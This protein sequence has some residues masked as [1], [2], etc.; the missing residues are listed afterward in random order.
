MLLVVAT[1]LALCVP[2]LAADNAVVVDSDIATYA[3]SSSL[4]SLVLLKPWYHSGA[5]ASVA[6]DGD[7][8]SDSGSGG[9]GIGRAYDCYLYSS[10]P[11]SYSKCDIPRDYAFYFTVDGVEH[12]FYWEFSTIENSSGD[13]ST[14][15]YS[16]YD[17]NRRWVS[18]S[19]S[20]SLDFKWFVYYQNTSK[21]VYMSAQAYYLRDDGSESWFRG[22][23][24]SGPINSYTLSASYSY[25]ASFSNVRISSVRPGSSEP[26]PS[27]ESVNYS[28][29]MTLA[30]YSQSGF[31]NSYP[32]GAY[33]D[34]P[35]WTEQLST[36]KLYE[37][38]AGSS[39]SNNF[40]VSV[41]GIDGVDA[42]MP[43]ATLY[44]YSVDTNGDAKDLLLTNSKPCPSLSDARTYDYT[45]HFTTS[46]LKS[47]KFYSS[48]LLYRLELTA[49][50][51][52][53]FDGRTV[54][55]SIP[56]GYEVFVKR[57]G[58]TSSDTDESIDDTTKDIYGEIVSNNA[59][60][61]A[62]LNTI[63]DLLKQL[64]TKADTINLS[65]NKCASLIPS[66]SSGGGS[67]SDWTHDTGGYTWTQDGEA[68]LTVPQYLGYALSAFKG[69]IVS[70][71]IALSPNG[72]G[73][74][75]TNYFY[76]RWAQ[77]GD[78]VTDA[79]RWRVQTISDNSQYSWLYQVANGVQTS[80]M[81]AEAL[82]NWSNPSY[83]MSAPSE[84]AN[85]SWFNAVLDALQGS[86]TDKPLEDAT[87]DAKDALTDFVKDEKDKITDSI[88]IGKTLTDALDT[89]LS[90][91]QTNSTISGLFDDTSDTYY[92]WF[93]SETEQDLFPG[94][95]DV[96]TQSADVEPSAQDVAD[97]QVEWVLVPYGSA[98]DLIS[99]FFGGDDQ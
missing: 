33:T 21:G 56:S 92:R 37:L 75:S 89:G 82:M 14:S 32:E 50:S 96:S 52:K 99:D 43:S 7:S 85:Y 8:G 94:A 79:N 62:K 22:Y 87:E 88:S 86:E 9:S 80:G 98:S 41:S 63:I 53:S 15:L 19:F 38:P 81:V 67:S 12:S 60:V 39:I 71:G 90:I 95:S 17:G 11:N 5:G 59:N 30:T 69:K 13:S 72:L 64:L 28:F 29:G 65:I 40:T 24:N 4:D 91:D 97:S 34:F 61:I 16:V 83:A 78:N 3:D 23:L 27:V 70:S 6:V 76:S 48:A 47:A 20:S 66:G 36:N 74:D 18:S 58:S 10:I 35:G 73:S 1:L 49:E 84:T 93:S 44:V 68:E 26:S 46:L 45:F 31:G 77:F 54:S 42:P 55:F 51:G 25:P 57:L 2:A